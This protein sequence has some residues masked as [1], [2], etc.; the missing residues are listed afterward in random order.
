M[1]FNKAFTF[2]FSDQDWV[3]KVLIFIGLSIISILIIPSF[4]ISGYFIKTIERVARGEEGLPEWGEWGDLITIGLKAFVVGLVLSVPM[5][6]IF[7]IFGV[8]LVSAL[9]TGSSSLTAAAGG[10]MAIGMLL[11]VVYGMA[12]ACVGPAM[13]LQFIREGYSIGAAFK[14]SEVIGIITA[15]IGDYALAVV[16]SVVAFGATSVVGSFIPII[17]GLILMPYAYGVSGHLFGQVLAKTSLPVQ[18]ADSLA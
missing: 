10:G 11:A 3:K 17:G 12:M 16:L 2:I 13:L 18:A 9:V 8:T 6:V 14:V 4:I 15:D 7:G 1:D 5:I